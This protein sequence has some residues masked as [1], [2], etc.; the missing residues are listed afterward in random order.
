M[1]YPLSVTTKTTPFTSDSTEVPEGGLAGTPGAPASP[2]VRVVSLSGADAAHLALHN[3]DLAECRFF[4]T[5]RLDQLRLEGQCP[6]IPA[7][8][9][10]S[11]G[12]RRRTARRASTRSG[13]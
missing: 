4:G 13:T 7:A 1:E 12:W 11:W 10:W 2:A 9:G 8:T 6:L 5:I 3:V